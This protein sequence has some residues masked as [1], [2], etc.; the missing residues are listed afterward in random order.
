MLT[1]QNYSIKE[2]KLEDGTIPDGFNCAVI[3]GP[4]ESFTD[5]EL[6]Q[7]D[8]FLMRGK[9]LALFLDAFKEVAPPQQQSFGFNRPASYVPID[10]GLEKLLVH[11]GVRIRKSYVMDENCYRQRV[12]DRF[13]GGE[14]PFYFAP[15]IQ[16]QNINHDVGFMKNIKGLVAMTISPLGLDTKRIK[17]NGLSACKLFSSSTKSWEMKGQINLHPRFIRPP[18]SSEEQGSLPLA[19]ILE[20]EFPSYFAGKA[21]PE[22]KPGETDVDEDTEK[23]ADKKP[24]IDLSQIESEG[25]FLLK[26]KP[27]KIFIMASSEMLKDNI[28]DVQ[29]RSP[30]A[31]FIMNVLDYL[32]NLEGIAVMRSKEQRFNPLNDTKAGTKVFV[33]SFNIAGLPLLVVLFGL[34]VWFRRH[35]RKK[36]I[37]MMFQK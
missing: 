23:T 36:R 8:Q 29:G 22:K 15:I 28:L 16:S 31:M 2:F 35:A 21:I 6:F 13:G 1:S 24:D 9:N 17:E 27:G 34:L 19:Y 32:N 12:P 30:N 18:Q 37:Q 25:E 11:Y 20:G 7:I 14:T 10:T 3:A 33:K 5:Y 26:G 4:M